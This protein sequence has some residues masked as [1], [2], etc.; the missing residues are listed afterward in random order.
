VAVI[1]RLKLLCA[2]M[3]LMNLS[4]QKFFLYV[5]SLR[6]EDA[7]GNDEMD[8]S[9]SESY[10]VLFE[11]AIK[12]L[13]N[14]ELFRWRELIRSSLP[15]TG[16]RAPVIGYGIDGIR[17]SIIKTMTREDRRKMGAAITAI[18]KKSTRLT[19]GLRMWLDLFETILVF[20]AK[21]TRLIYP[22]LSQNDPAF[23][24]IGKGIPILTRGGIERGLFHRAVDLVDRIYAV[25]TTE[26]N[27]KLAKGMAGTGGKAMWSGGLI[28]PSVFGSIGLSHQT[29]MKMLT[30][31]RQSTLSVCCRAPPSLSLSVPASAA[32]DISSYEDE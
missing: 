15:S 25:L 8:R 22:E 2:E 32:Q 19:L 13:K 17:T 20:Y 5:P 27:P 9:L 26:M 30:I 21:L 24:L 31:I 11:P 6:T 1:Q 7:V 12:E 3:F 29:G 23:I 14:P 4:V 18:T 16:K 28:C 10:L